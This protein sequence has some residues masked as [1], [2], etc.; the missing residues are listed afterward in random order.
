MYVDCLFWI[1]MLRNHDVSGLIGSNRDGSQVEGP[2]VSPNLLEDWTIARVTGEEKSLL[3]CEDGIATPQAVP[4][5]SAPVAPML[6][7]IH[8]LVHYTVSED[9]RSELKLLL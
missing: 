2:I 4:S 8:N 5:V 9:E 1:T 3:F 6:H 7:E